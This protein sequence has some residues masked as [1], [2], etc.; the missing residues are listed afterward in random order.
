MKRYQDLFEKQLKTAV[1]AQKRR[2]AIATA[3][4]MFAIV[5]WGVNFAQKDPS[6]I[7]GVVNEVM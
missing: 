6:F 7:G 1:N 4:F 3:Q 5:G 2:Q